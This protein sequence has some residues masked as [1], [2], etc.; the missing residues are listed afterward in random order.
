M[1][2]SKTRPLFQAF[3]NNDAI[4]PNVGSDNGVSGVSGCSAYSPTSYPGSYISAPRCEKTLILAGYVSPRIYRFKSSNRPQLKNAEELYGNTFPQNERL[5]H[6]ICQLCERRL[7]NV[8]NFKK[9]MV[10]TC[11][12]LQQRGPEFFSQRAGSEDKTL[13]TRLL[14]PIGVL[15]WP[16]TSSIPNK[17]P[18]ILN[19]LYFFLFILTHPVNFTCGRKP[20]NLE[21]NHDFRQSVDEF[22]PREIRCSIQDSNPWPQWSSEDVAW[23]TESPKPQ[24]NKDRILK[25]W[26]EELRHQVLHAT[27]FMSLKLR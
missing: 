9:I 18:I 5:P 2:R 27:I 13:G 19:Y 8:M 22:F 26:A 16:V 10:E 12:L 6:L 1:Y 3:S 14:I 21:K 7:N 15:Q 20:E 24:R 17:L 25:T 4:W 23:T 11:D